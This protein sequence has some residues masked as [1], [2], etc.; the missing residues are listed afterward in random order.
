MSGAIGDGY[1]GSVGALWVVHAVRWLYS[2]REGSAGYEG[3]CV[4]VVRAMG[5]V[6]WVCGGRVGYGGYV[7]EMK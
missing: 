3:G 2:G 5:A 7:V 6:R 4:V 1:G